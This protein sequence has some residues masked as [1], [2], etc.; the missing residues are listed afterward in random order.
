MVN[1]DMT[2][3]F[4]A[5]T[6]HGIGGINIPAKMARLAT[7][8]QC[9]PSYHPHGSSDCAICTDMNS[10][11]HLGWILF[12]PLVFVIGHGI[13]RIDIPAEMA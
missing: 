10:Q 9:R 4:P 7:S 13:G 1:S 11:I 2:I 3:V 6:S 5:V 12:F 8:F